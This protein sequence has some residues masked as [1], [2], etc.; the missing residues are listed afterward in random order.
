MVRIDAFPDTFYVK[1]KM[2][3]KW[4][5]SI[6][7]YMDNDIKKAMKWGRKKIKIKYAVLKDSIDSLPTTS[8]LN[9]DE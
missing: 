3:P 9:S 2:H 1:D 8:Q 7:I 5:N 4:R 6:D